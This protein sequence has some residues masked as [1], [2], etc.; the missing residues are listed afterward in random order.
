MLAVSIELLTGR[1]AATRFDNRRATEWPPHPARLF[2]AMVAAWADADDPDP[3][4]RDALLWLEALGAPDIVASD[5]HDRARVV[6]YVPNNE[7]DSAV[8]RDLSSSYGKLRELEQLERDAEAEGDRKA[9]DKHRKALVKLRAKIETDSERGGKAK[10]TESDSAVAAGVQLLPDERGRQARH[11]P[12]C[13]PIDPVVHFVWPQAPIGAPEADVVDTILSRVARL[14]HS[15]SMVACAVRAETPPPTFTPSPD[16][17]INM[18]VPAPGLLEE[19]EIAFA[20]HQGIEPRVLPNVIQ[21]YRSTE[22]DRPELRRTNLG[23]QWISLAVGGGSVLPI[24]A[25]MGMAVAVRGA[26]LRYADEPI[27]PVLSGHKGGQGPTAPSDAPHLAVLPLPF[28]GHRHADG[29]IRGVALVL[30]SGTTPQ[31][32]GALSGAVDRWLRSGDGDE[33]I[34]NLGRAGRR[35]VSILAPA[36]APSTARASTW[37]RPSFEWVS[38]TPVA[39]DR[40]PKGLWHPDPSLH[41]AAEQV[42]LATIRRSCTHV[43]LPEPERIRIS[44]QSPLRGVPPVAQFPMYRSPGRKVTRASV[45]VQLTFAERVRGPVSIGAGRYFGQGLMLPVRSGD[46]LSGA[47]P[48]QDS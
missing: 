15:S 4:E 5:A 9:A 41:N 13:I 17:E 42:I 25:A 22:F 32:I 37:G 21:P 36:D 19:L 40:Y 10:D 48:E 11:F 39:L 20:A 3:I 44:R 27:P 35:T 1:Y 31:E 43:G 38:V 7:A 30:P 24:T 18:R 6:F 23:G 33:G 28:V 34:L 16:G 26:I 29:G 12:T 46:G 2:S 8:V 45:H 14:G 47:T